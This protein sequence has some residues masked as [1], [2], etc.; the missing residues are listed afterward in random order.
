ME[1]IPFHRNR[2]CSNCTLCESADNVCIPARAL[3]DNQIIR[4]KKALLFV[5]QSPGHNENKQDKSFIGYTGGILKTFVEGSGILEYCDVYLANAV[6][7]R[8]PQ[9]ANETQSQI[10][11][12]RTYL[13]DDIRELKKEYEDIIVM[14]LGAK[15]CYSVSGISSLNEGF[16]R[17]AMISPV[18][19][20]EGLGEIP[21]FFSNHP[22]ILHPSRQP[23][24]ARV[25][26]SHFDLLL[27]YLTGDFVPNS[28]QANYEIGAPVPDKLSDTVVVDIETYGILKGRE[29]TVFNPHKSFYVDKVPYSKQVI[30]VGFTIKVEGELK[31]FTYIW[32]N[33]S[34]RQII[35]RWFRRIVKEH[36]TCGGQNLKFDLMYLASSKD[37]E[38]A[39]WIDPRRLK[40]DDLMILAF[41]LF[42]QQPEKGLKELALLHG[43]YDYSRLEVTGKSGNAKSSKDPRLHQYQAVDCAVTYELIELVKREIERR[44][45]KNSPKL[46]KTCEWV[47]NAIIWD[48][49][50]LEFNGS[51][52]DVSRLEK[53]HN[54]LVGQCERIWNACYEKGN[55]KLSGKGSDKPLRD[56]MYECVVEAD[57]LLDDRVLWSEKT[58]K[59][60]IGAENV[61]LVKDYLPRGKNRRIM[62][63]F[64][65]HNRKSKLISTYTGPLLNKPQK[66]IVHV[67][68]NRGM[69]YPTWYPIPTYNSRGG[70]SDNK[71]GGQIQGRFSCQK[72]ARQT[73]PESIRRCTT[74]RWEGGKVVEY[75]VNADHLRMAA[76]L[77]GDP[78]LVAAYTEESESLHAQTA[79]T[80][81]PD[82]PPESYPSMKDFKKTRYYKLGKTLNYA[83]LFKC[84]AGT[85]Q[86]TCLHDEG[87][88]VELDFCHE[89]IR[90]WYK[91]H[92]VY[93]AW[94]DKMISKA[95]REGFLQ[96]PTGWSRTFGPPGGDVSAFEGE[97]LNFLHQCPCAQL[98]QSS[99]YK[100]SHILRRNYLNS[101]ICLQIYDALFF[102]IY[103]REEMDVDEIAVDVMTNPPLLEVFYEWA[104]REIPWDYEK[105]EYK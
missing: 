34:H 64:Q 54:K 51:T 101:K 90:R 31:N 57:L 19:E 55:L 35:R 103:P 40:V 48:T 87:I 98:L 11:K 47:R 96:L 52:L 67:R 41:L 86:Q 25:M 71:S 36:R 105:K 10:R 59:I 78:V 75:D 93:R 29:Q 91:K 66:G 43:V 63:L 89:A 16:K 1:M 6:R 82:N 7:C 50:D 37:K 85:F 39:Y 88:E 21:L 18:F 100:A 53:Y 5:G 2:D 72:P 70:S 84:S 33:P 32:S 8:P 74:S 102:D 22:A 68:S 15:A 56:F 38:L 13:L 17:Q 73:E 97:V 76:L 58:G 62:S 27:R 99:Q 4:R 3:Y 49:F 28:L 42:E 81:F 94:Q 12:C 80:I 44:Y 104:G 24:L 79:R 23:S 77:S 65:R 26:Q 30:T 45:G 9:K 95:A 46:G 14:A 69:V 92:S 83:V 20:K 60:S 61:N